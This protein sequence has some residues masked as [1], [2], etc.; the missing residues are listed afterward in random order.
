M[1]AGINGHAAAAALLRASAPQVVRLPT[2]IAP[3]LEE[4]EAI[5]DD[6]STNN[7]IR[8]LRALLDLDGVLEVVVNEPGIALVETYKGWT[9]HVVPELTFKHLTE[10]AVSVA[11]Y[12][13]QKIDERTPLLSA[14]LP[15]QERIQFV[16]PS[17]TAQ[18]VVA[19]AMRKPSKAVRRLDELEQSGLFSRLLKPRTGLSATQRQLLDFKR[20]GHFADFFK[21]AARSKLNI[22]L[23]GATGSGKT[24]F[25]KALC[26]EIPAHERV[27]TIEDAA[28]L[29]LEGRANKA[30]L[31]YSKGRQG[32]S[33]ITA[34]ALLEAC[35]RLRP[36]RIIQAE[37]R[38]EEA[39]SFLNVAA[40]GH[41][42]SMTTLHAG[43]CDEVFDRIALMV[44]MSRAGSG[45]T[46]AEIDRMARRVIDVVVHFQREDGGF[47]IT[48]IYYDP[49]AKAALNT[50]AASAAPYQSAAA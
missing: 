47:G 50:A 11:T 3:M 23:A 1:S 32:I 27:I 42:G 35:L 49:E 9:R 39:F 7:K 41:P 28:E 37:L 25:L 30:H 48:G 19:I 15:T 31:F 10:L 43:S 46:M 38:G 22:V 16:T 2:P 45:M 34:E 12:T 20:S 13:G 26:E 18:G 29:L 4:V 21:L 6:V 17:A 5:T 24:N 33:D 40:S 8:P 14:T 36:D 44:R